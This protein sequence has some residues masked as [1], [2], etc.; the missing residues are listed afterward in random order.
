MPQVKIEYSKEAGLQNEQIDAL[1][2]YINKVVMKFMKV[3]VD[4]TKFRAFELQQSQIGAGENYTSFMHIVVSVLRKTERTQD[5]FDEMCNAILN[6]CAKEIDI[7]KK[8]I[9]VELRE[10][11][12]N[13]YY[14]F[15]E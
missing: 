3:S 11:D 9:S 13:K 15:K 5:V 12:S 8:C 1:F 7:N 4:A 6:Y 14:N 2:G 10:M